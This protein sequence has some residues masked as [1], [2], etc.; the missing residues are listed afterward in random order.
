MFQIIPYVAQLLSLRLCYFIV[1][2]L[3][4]VFRKPVKS[5]DP[6]VSGLVELV[7]FTWRPNASMASLEK[8]L[9]NKR[10]YFFKATTGW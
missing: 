7:A 5:V 1:A 6:P 10:A 9:W 4:E 2:F 3:K 8:I